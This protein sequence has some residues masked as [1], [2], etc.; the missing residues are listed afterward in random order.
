MNNDQ[1]YFKKIMLPLSSV[2]QRTRHSRFKAFIVLRYLTSELLETQEL[3]KPDSVIKDLRAR[4]NR[5]MMFFCKKYGLIH[6]AINKFYLSE[7]I[8]YGD[9]KNT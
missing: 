7:N 1:M 4:L 2:M 5:H 6:S 3:V 8:F 9:L